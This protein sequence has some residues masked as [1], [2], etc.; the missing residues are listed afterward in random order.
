MVIVP[1]VIEDVSLKV[2]SLIGCAALL[3]LVARVAVCPTSKGLE[4]NPAEM[5]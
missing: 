1:V 4:A 3:K 5:L 2:L